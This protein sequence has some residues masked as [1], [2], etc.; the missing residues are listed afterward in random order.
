MRT[1]D[2]Q[3]TYGLWEDNAWNYQF[4]NQFLHGFLVAILTTIISYQ[5]TALLLDAYVLPHHRG[6]ARLSTLFCLLLAEDTRP[7]SVLSALFPTKPL[8]S[9]TYNHPL[10]PGALQTPP[11]RLRLTRVLLVLLFVLTAP[12]INLLAIIIGLET[13]W[14]ITF[15]ESQFGGMALGFN[16]SGPPIRSIPIT[17]MCRQFIAN[18]SQQDWG[19]ADFFI[20]NRLSGVPLSSPS[21]YNYIEARTRDDGVLQVIAFLRPVAVRSETFVDV[22]QPDALWRLHSVIDVQ[23]LRAIVGFGL[24]QVLD[25]CRE[26]GVGPVQLLRDDSGIIV[27]QRVGFCDKEVDTEMLASE[28][29]GT[30]VQNATVVDVPPLRM[31]RLDE[32]GVG[33]FVDGGSR[34]I[35]KRRRAVLGLGWLAMVAGVCV[36][37]RIVVGAVVKN[38]LYLGLEIITRDTVGG[39][40]MDSMLQRDTEWFGYFDGR[41]TRART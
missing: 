31:A 6:S 3:L 28:V 41:Q 40:G 11:S 10:P 13:E 33:G 39:G 24:G 25:K 26:G 35:V 14:D 18:Y 8:I 22:R 34:F 38:D 7:L 36:A 2:G 16:N 32:N 1:I 29:V 20:C 12:L 19:L 4:E 30:A 5:A 23:D 9:L 17:T 15:E 37:G 21:S 27:R